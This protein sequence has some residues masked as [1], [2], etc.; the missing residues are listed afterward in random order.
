MYPFPFM[1]KGGSESV[2]ESFLSLFFQEHSLGWPQTCGIVK[3]NL[4]LLSLLPPLEC[5]HWASSNLC[6]LVGLSP[7]EGLQLPL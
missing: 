3:D 5:W 6:L 7:H 4:E 1:E 2:P